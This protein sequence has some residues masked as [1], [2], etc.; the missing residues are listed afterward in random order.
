MDNEPSAGAAKPKE[1]TNERGGTPLPSSKVVNEPVPSGSGPSR[2]VAPSQRATAATAKSV[3]T[4]SKL[5]QGPNR[6]MEVDVVAEDEGQEEE[7]Q[8]NRP[9]RDPLS[10]EIVMQLEKGLQR[11]SGFG[12]EGWM[13]D[14]TTVSGYFLSKCVAKSVFSGTNH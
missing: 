4:P 7:G 12:E 10:E 8:R 2:P 3:Q 6:D 11:W 9:E 13:G 5:V 14:V 1:T